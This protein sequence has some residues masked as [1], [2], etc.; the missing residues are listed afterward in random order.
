[1]ERSL[2]ETKV[3]MIEALVMNAKKTELL[4]W[5]F[6]GFFLG[7]AGEYFLTVTFFQVKQK[8]YI[9]H[10]EKNIHVLLQQRGIRWQSDLSVH[11][12]PHYY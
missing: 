10:L 9:S 1:M 11:F 12:P 3:R 5:F 6:A 8:D 7:I 4:V 2:E